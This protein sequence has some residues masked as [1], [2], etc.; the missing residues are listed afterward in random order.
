MVATNM[1]LWSLECIGS[2][3]YMLGGKL[4]SL[5][6][7]DATCTLEVKFQDD[8]WVGFNFYFIIVYLFILRGGAKATL[9]VCVVL[10]P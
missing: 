4:Y 9:V 5:R 8:K 10:N 6:R 7:I 1:I 2:L 3:Y